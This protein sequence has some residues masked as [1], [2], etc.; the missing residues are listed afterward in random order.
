MK[1]ISSLCGLMLL[2][3]LVIAPMSAQAGPGAGPEPGENC[4]PIADNKVH[5]VAPPYIVEFMSIYVPIG[6]TGYGNVN[7]TTTVT[8]PKNKNCKRTK[9]VYA[10]EMSASTFTEQSSKKALNSLCI[11]NIVYSDSG[12]IMF[13]STEAGLYLEVIAVTEY[14]KVGNT[15]TATLVVME[16]FF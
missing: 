5:Y 3:L 4:K 12:E 10:P 16:I 6:N 14:K 11:H 9:H 15:V 7:T 13:C 8:S 2:V 1:A